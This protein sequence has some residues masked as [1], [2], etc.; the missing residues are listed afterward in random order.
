MHLRGLF[1]PAR[2]I[3]LEQNPNL[4]IDKSEKEKVIGQEKKR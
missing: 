4:W 1:S 2:R 3:D